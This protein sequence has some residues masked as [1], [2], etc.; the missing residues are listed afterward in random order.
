MLEAPVE[1]HYTVCKNNYTLESHNADGA[2]ELARREMRSSRNPEDCW[3]LE[4]RESYGV[5]LAAD[6][7]RA[8]LQLYLPTELGN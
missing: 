4:V 1:T 8:N 7:R 6:P 2:S 5:H 3:I